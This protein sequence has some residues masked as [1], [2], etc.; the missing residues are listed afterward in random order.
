[1][2]TF[3]LVTA[4]AIVLT[5]LAVLFVPGVDDFVEITFQRY[6]GRAAT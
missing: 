3:Y 2:K 5:V 6:L 4:G 1:M